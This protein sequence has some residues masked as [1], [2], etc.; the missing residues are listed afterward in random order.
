MDCSPPGSS[1]HGVFQARVLEWGAIAFSGYPLLGDTKDP[2]IWNNIHI[3]DTLGNFYLH[4]SD[5]FV[6]KWAYKNFV[7]G[8]Q[9][10]DCWSFLYKSCRD[11][12]HLR[13]Q[14]AYFKAH[15]CFSFDSPKYASFFK[16]NV[17]FWTNFRFIEKLPMWYRAFFFTF[18]QPPLNITSYVTMVHLSKL[19]N[20]HYTLLLSKR[21]VL[22]WISRV[23]PL[24]F[25]FPPGPHT[26]THRT[27]SSVS[28]PLWKF[29]SVPW[30]S[31]TLTVLRS[32]G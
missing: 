16:I 18:P 5:L 4:Y 28:S 3:W 21:Q 15:V 12:S 26:G 29:R 25:L 20:K 9:N 11:L 6:I 22:L 2:W 13:N 8:L 10:I 23:F 7:N 1:A 24:T 14:G 19:W 31:M 30:F 32:P 17:L 27:V